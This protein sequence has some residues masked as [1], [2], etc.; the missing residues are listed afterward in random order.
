ML[1]AVVLA[2]IRARSVVLYTLVTH[3]ELPG[4]AKVRYKR[5]ERFVQFA[6]PDTYLASLVLNLLPQG[7]Q[8]LILDRTHCLGPT[9]LP[10]G[11]GRWKLSRKHINILLLSVVWK[12]FSLPLVWT[13]LTTGGNSTQV[14]RMALVLRVQRVMPQGC[15]IGVLVD[16]EF[17]DQDWFMFLRIH[18]IKICIRLKKDAR[19]DGLPIQACFLQMEP[20]ELRVWHRPMRIYGVKLR[21]LALCCRDGQ[22]LYLAY[23]GHPEAGLRRYAQRWQCENL[24]QS[25]KGRGF[26][27]EESGLSRPERVSTLMGAVGLAFVWCC[28]TGEYR[29]KQIAVSVLSHGYPEQSIFRYG[30]QHLQDLFFRVI[31]CET[32]EQ[33]RLFSLFDP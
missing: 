27:L 33:L 5:L 6:L 31:S 19:V 28:L 12:G 23:Q 1:Y 10:P 13:V 17:V 4:D 7:P 26:N 3:L 14:Q 2:M 21:I 20:G 11:A 30:L 25:L 24:H 18:K 22:M 9:T 29:Q 32:R 8:W 15:S 16:R